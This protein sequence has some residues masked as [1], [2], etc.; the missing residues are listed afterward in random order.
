MADKEL[1]G[2]EVKA[3][4]ARLAIK[5]ANLASKFEGDKLVKL[6]IGVGLL[7]HAQGIA[8]SDKTKANRILAK[9]KS[10]IK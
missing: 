7:N 8:D 9:V 10:L 3:E 2:K 5:A 1:T 4:L 6:N